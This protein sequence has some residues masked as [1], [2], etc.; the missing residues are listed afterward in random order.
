MGIPHVTDVI[1]DARARKFRGQIRLS[2]TDLSAAIRVA[3][4][5]LQA[6][7]HARIVDALIGEGARYV[8]RKGL[9]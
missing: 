4:P 7:S 3:A 8:K 2:H 9:I 1:Y 5:G 6:W